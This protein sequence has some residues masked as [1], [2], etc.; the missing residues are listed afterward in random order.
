M[1]SGGFSL[2]TQ[3]SD[4][5]WPAAG[6]F[7]GA[8][9][10]TEQLQA[11]KQQAQTVALSNSSEAADYPPPFPFENFN[12]VTI[13]KPHVPPVVQISFKTLSDLIKSGNSG[14]F[15]TSESASW[16]KPDGT[17]VNASASMQMQ[18]RPLNFEIQVDAFIPQEYVPGPGFTDFYGGDMR[19]SPLDGSFISGNAIFNQYM[20]YRLRQKGPRNG[21]SGRAGP[22]RLA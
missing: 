13:G 14:A 18:I 20:G 11:P 15:S 16:T 12:Q 1:A 17:Q 19:K 9:T 5:L 3:G 21:N 22:G 2:V 4:I 8:V 7:S 6:G 10:G